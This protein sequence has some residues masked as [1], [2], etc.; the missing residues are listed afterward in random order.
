MEIRRESRKKET[1][2]KC[3]TFREFVNVVLPRGKSRQGISSLLIL[4]RDQLG[5]FRVIAVTKVGRT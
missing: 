5:V 1:Q 4:K 2:L 3:K